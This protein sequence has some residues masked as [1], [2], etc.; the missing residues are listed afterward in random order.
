MPRK[1]ISNSEIIFFMNYS[2]RS[3]GTKGGGL[4]MG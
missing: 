2:F 3:C 1:P 4:Q